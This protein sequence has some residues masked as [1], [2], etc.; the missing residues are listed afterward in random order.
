MTDC[1]IPEGYKKTKI[2]V[3][4]VEWNVTILE[5]LCLNK[6]DYGINAPAVPYSKGLP[7]YLRITDIDDDGRFITGNKTS[8]DNSNNENYHLKEGDIVFARTGATVGKT[9]LYN[10]NDGD[11]VFAGFLIRFSPDTKQIDPYFLKA[12][13]NTTIYWKWIKIVSQRSGQPGINAKEY[14]SLQI[15]VPSLIEQK[16]ISEVLNIWDK[17][18]EKQTQLIDKLELRK[19]GLMQQLLTG[20]KRLPGFSGEWKKVKLG[21]ICEKVTRKNTEDNKNVMTISAQQGFVIQTDFFNKSVASETL[22]SYYLVLRDEF[23]YNKSYSNGYPMGAIKRLTEADKAVVTSLY[24]C[25]NVKSNIRVSIDYLSYYFDYGG[26]NRGLTKIANEGGRAHGLLNVTPTDFFRLVFDIPYYEE[27][28]AIAQVLT[29]TDHEIEIAQQKLA[30]LR[31][32]KHG[33]MQQLLIGKKR[34]NY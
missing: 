18:I 25:F 26:L 10:P 16:K 14:C 4:P 13:T 27:Q 24:I 1:I 9:Y 12:Y 34:V 6:G 21:D 8:V 31:Q 30:L 23:C 28:N 19:K 17:A 22:E 5:H 11:L 32:Q 33:L 29:A 3:I 2:G 20:K 15:P 7:T